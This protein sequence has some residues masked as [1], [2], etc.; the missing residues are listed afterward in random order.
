M[1]P[2]DIFATDLKCGTFA[3]ITFNPP[4]PIPINSTS[5]TVTIT[6][7]DEGHYRLRSFNKYKGAAGLGEIRAPDQKVGAG[8]VKAEKNADGRY[9]IAITINKDTGNLIPSIAPDVGTHTMTLE[10]NLDSS[11]NDGWK[12]YCGYIN[13]NIGFV[14]TDC[15]LEYFPKDPHI[16]E[17]VCVRASN[18]PVK[19]ENPTLFLAIP[20]LYADHKVPDFVTWDV[21]INTNDYGKIL[22]DHTGIGSTIIGPF[23][24]RF[25]NASIYLGVSG[26]INA[27]IIGEENRFCDKTKI[28]ILETT[29]TPRQVSC[30]NLPPPPSTGSSPTGGSSGGSTICTGSGCSSAAGDATGCKEADPTKYIKTALG[31]VPTEPT[32]LIKKVIQL[33][34]GMAG[35]IAL[36]MMSIGALRMIMSAGSAE[37]LKEGQ[38]QFKSAIIGLLFIIFSVLL[39][40]IIG[41]DLLNIPNFK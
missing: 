9:Q 21:K 22:I 38:E 32:E 15:Q 24:E 13:Y 19:L 33:A 10:R 25:T 5:F 36:I 8:R 2:Q 3:A 37:A 30:S 27:P 35:G 41:V 31:C 28:S 14:N 12:D 26:S 7:I 20:D 40:Q 18:S 11:S 16:N 23:S 17:K 39:L 1:L 4:S 29:A 34:T 6:G